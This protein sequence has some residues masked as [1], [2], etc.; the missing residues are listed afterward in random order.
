VVAKR[1]Q[2]GSINGNKGA[3]RNGS[4]RGAGL[5]GGD[6]RGETTGE[7]ERSGKGRRNVEERK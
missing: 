7:K 3:K 2:E 4:R 6:I 5:E 1:Q